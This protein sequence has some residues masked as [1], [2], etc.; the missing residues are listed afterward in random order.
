MRIRSA[1]AAMRPTPPE[2][3]V[4]LVLQDNYG[5]AYAARSSE[6]HHFDDIEC[7]EV[8]AAADAG[9][10]IS[11]VGAWA[12]NL[13]SSDP[14]E[15]EQAIFYSERALELAGRRSRRAVLRQHR[16][17]TRPASGRALR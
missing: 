9:I 2:Q 1:D 6:R 11:E 16:G 17:I 4:E 3:W 12:A 8:Q 13:L 10:V 15:A 14:Q 5:A 7:Y